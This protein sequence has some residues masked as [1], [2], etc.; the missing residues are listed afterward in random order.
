MAAVAR[1]V[2]TFLLIVVGGV[3]AGAQTPYRTRV[4]GEF[5]AWLVSDI[6][7]EAKAAGVSRA[8]FDRAFN[9]VTL[10]WTA[11]GAGAAGSNT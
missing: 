6:W 8:T 7:P 11:A 10:D 9:G 3:D 2:A 4:E 5:Q 1:I